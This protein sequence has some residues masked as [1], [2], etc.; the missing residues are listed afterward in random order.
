MKFNPQ[1]KPETI[2]TE[3]LNF[4]VPKELQKRFVEVRAKAEKAG[5][6]FNATTIEALTEYAD[7]WDDL[8]KGKRGKVTDGAIPLS[9]GQS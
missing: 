7:N 8:L 9:N 6:D 1:R 4:R 2:E 3:Q 5:Y